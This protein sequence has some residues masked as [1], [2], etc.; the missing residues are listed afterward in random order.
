[1]SCWDNITT[2]LTSLENA[3]FKHEVTGIVFLD[4][5]RAFDTCDH[6]AVLY[7]CVK[8]GI[9]PLIVRIIKNYLCDRTVRGHLDSVFTS[10]F[11]ITQGVPQGGALSP[12][13]FNVLLHRLIFKLSFY[14]HSSIFADDIVIWTTAER[15]RVSFIKDA[16]H[17]GLDNIPSFFPSRFF[18]LS[19]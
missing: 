8:A 18:N 4:I 10:S 9:D 12:L 6:L 17:D 19:Y 11:P 13:L 16:L 7:E 3:R 15:N 1:M 5:S 2:L 14:V